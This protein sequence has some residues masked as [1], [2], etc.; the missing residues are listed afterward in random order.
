MRAWSSAI[1]P[2]LLGAVPAAAT[3]LQGEAQD[4]SAL[5]I[6]ELAQI[7][8]RSASK[9]EEPLSG[10]PTAL[11]VIT[12]TDIARS[13]AT[14]L[15]EV[16][17]MAPN[18]DVERV[19]ATQ[20]AITARGFNGVEESNKLLVLIDGRSIYS[21]LH[22]GVFWELHSPLLEDLQQIEVISGPGG[23]LYGP[24]AVNGVIN[25]TS[26]D[27]SQTLGGLVRGT[28][29]ANERT[30]GAR[31]GVQLGENGAIR[32]YA[33]YFDR[34]GMP[35]VTGANA[36]DAL[37]GWQAGVR[38]DF[39]GDADHFTLQGDFFDTDTFAVPGD[40][41]RGGNV[42]AR[43]TRELTSRSSFQ[44]QAYYDY[45]R[46]DSLLTVD[47]LE[48]MDAQA[49][50]SLRG[51]AHDLVAGIGIR[52]SRDKFINNL[53][54]FQLDPQ[55]DRTWVWNGFVQDRYALTPELS[56]TVGAKLEGSSLA[57]VQ[58]LPNLRLAWQPG[59]RALLWAAVSRAVRTP[60]RI[61]RGLMAPPLLITAPDFKVEKLTAFEAGYRGQPGPNTSL[62]ISLFY[63]LYH[64]LRTLAFVGNPFPLQLANDL[65]GHSY[66]FEAWGTQQVLAW[67]RLS[68]GAAVLRKSFE[69][70]PGAIDLSGRA[71]LGH[72]PDFRLSLRSQMTLPH[73]ITIDAD[74]RAIDALE[75]PHVDGYVELGA[76]IGWVIRDGIELYLAGENLLHRT[77]I[78]SNDIDRAQRVQRNISVGTRLRF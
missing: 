35:P 65:R 1:L 3:G 41:G 48:T 51:A 62:S 5:S 8:V 11:Y 45:F 55:R 58:L 43:W 10:A 68:A 53:N 20:H 23:T 13:T 66:G 71:S 6:E 46:I 16:L 67:W 22:S 26:K 70:R 72:D 9:H 59:S 69:V 64:D 47:V 27:A 78:E 30:L 15:P 33:N 39:D 76:R 73:G 38:A 21:T 24:N 19:N 28:A 32:A 63:N 14:S 7:P 31:Y 54:A 40:G 42:V 34:E 12:D 61:D 37:R 52:T 29:S 4:L 36:S 49:Q 2:L 44:L 60:S 56:V 74:L 18:L 17:R 57:G 25:V 77:H 50:Y 75:D